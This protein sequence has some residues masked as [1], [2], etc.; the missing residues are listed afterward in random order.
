M[1]T[2]TWTDRH[3]FRQAYGRR[4]TWTDRHM[5]KR[6]HRHMD[7]QRHGH[8]HMFRHKDKQTHILTDI[9]GEKHKHM[10]PKARNTKCI[11]QDC[12]FYAIPWKNPATNEVLSGENS[13]WFI[14][15]FLVWEPLPVLAA[16]RGSVGGKGVGMLR[17]EP[18]NFRSLAVSLNAR[19]TIAS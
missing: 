11:L 19:G 15:R 17:S 2:D 10:I 5:D 13:H 1:N 12:S 4:G 16:R 9:D 6:T 8:R 3:L 18:R 14:R 7:R